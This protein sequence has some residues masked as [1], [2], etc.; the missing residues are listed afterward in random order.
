VALL[1]VVLMGPSK[2][3]AAVS[4]RLAVGAM[5]KLEV[6]AQAPKQSAVGLLDSEGRSTSLAAFRGKVVLVNFWATWCAPCMNELPTLAVLQRRYG[7]PGFSVVT[8]NIDADS[9]LP[10]ARTQ[11][12]RLSGGAL[13]FI[14]DP[15]RSIEFDAQAKAMPTS[16]L[17]D[18]QGRELARVTGDTD[19]SKPEANAVID[20]ALGR[21]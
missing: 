1:Y 5:S 2:P 14:S 10:E 7:G 4:S 17:Y 8:I 21:S 12:A 19:W 13:P 6:L 11:L 20:A 3:P 9:T 16:I 18:A 15:S